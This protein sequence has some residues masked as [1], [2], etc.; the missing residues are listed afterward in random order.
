MAKKEGELLQSWVKRKG[1]KGQQIADILGIERTSIYY[2]YKD[3]VLTK[4][5]KDKL[6]EH[7][8]NVDEETTLL[9]NSQKVSSNSR[10]DDIFILQGQIDL[11]S[12]QLMEIKE[13]LTL[14]GEDI[15]ELQIVTLKKRALKKVQGKQSS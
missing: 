15:K 6:D 9:E 14:Q 8:F 4:E 3:D 10:E 1:Y 7:G 12:K 2:V 11:L 13:G 5:Y